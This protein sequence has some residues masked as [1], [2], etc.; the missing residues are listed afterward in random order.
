MKTKFSLYSMFFGRIG[1][2]YRQYMIAR[3]KSWTPNQQVL[4]MKQQIIRNKYIIISII[5]IFHNNSI[6]IMDKAT[7]SLKTSAVYRLSF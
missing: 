4:I 2:T 1:Y 5:I 6:Q 3:M 7:N